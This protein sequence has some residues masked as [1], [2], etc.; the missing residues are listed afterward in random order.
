MITY[1]WLAFGCINGD[2]LQFIAILE[3]TVIKTNT[4]IQ[5]APVTQQN[6]K[7]GVCPHNSHI[8][9]CET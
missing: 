1:I 6:T 7:N 3:K 2:T 5:L 4:H 8:V 9:Y